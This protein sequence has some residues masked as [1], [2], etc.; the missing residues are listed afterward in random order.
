MG[1]PWEGATRAQE[2]LGDD[3]ATS[4]EVVE[5]AWEE[6][7]WKRDKGR[8]TQTEAHAKLVG[9]VSASDLGL[10]T[11][12]A[13]KRRMLAVVKEDTETMLVWVTRVKGIAAEL[14]LVGARTQYHH[15]PHLGPYRELQAPSAALASLEDHRLTL[16]YIIARLLGYSKIDGMVDGTEEE[17]DILYWRGPTTAR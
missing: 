9:C 8:M 13:I 10:S 4:E 12:L 1:D 14:R 5:A 6:A 7:M 11:Q 3:L 2:A 15:C 17:E 16:K